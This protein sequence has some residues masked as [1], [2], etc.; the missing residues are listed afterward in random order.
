MFYIYPANRMEDLLTLFIKIRHLKPLPILAKEVVMVQSQGLQHWLNME[1]ANANKI[2][3]N[4]DFVLPAQYLWKL[5]RNLCEDKFPEQTPYSREVLSWRIDNL[6][7]SERVL[8]DE[9]CRDANIYWQDDL[10]CQPLKR[11]QLACQLADLYEQYLIYR[12]EWLSSWR[13]GKAIADSDHLFAKTEQWQMAIWQHLQQE[14]SYDPQDLLTIAEQQIDDLKHLL[15]RRVSLFGINALAPMWLQFLDL[16]SEHIDVHVFHLNP[17]FEFWGDIQ[18]DKALAKQQYLQHIGKWPETIESSEGINPLLA[19]LGQQGRE[20]LSLLHNI[21]NIEIPLYDELYETSEESP[22]GDVSLL[23]RLQ[24]DILTLHD[25]RQSPQAIVDDSVVITSAHSALREVQGLHDYLLQLFNDDPQLTPK[26]VIVMCPQVESY[27]AYIDS[28]FVRGWEDVGE[29]VPPLPCSI[30]DRIS[31]ESEPL[32]HAFS[33]L[34]SMAD[35]RYSVAS[36]LSLLQLESVQQRFSIH[37]GDIDKVSDWLQKA[38]IYWGLDA[39]HKKH[40]LESNQQTDQFTWQQGLS[41]LIK[42]FAFVDQD[43]LLDESVVLANVEGNDAVL[44]G[45]IILFLEQLQVMQRLL[46]SKKTPNQWFEFLTNQVQRLFAPSDRDYGLEI[47]NNA[48]AQLQEYAEQATYQTPI[49]LNVIREFLNQHF[50]QPDPGRQFMIG[51]ITFCSMMPMRSIPFKVVAVLGLN[52]GEYPRQRTPL[53]FDLMQLSDAKAGD[54]S[55]RG[56]DKYL[57]LEAMISAR[58]H[59]YL[60]YQGRDIKNNNERQPSIVLRELMEYLH[61]A[62]KWDISDASSSQLRQL[63]LQAFAKENYIASTRFPS[64]DKNWLALTKLDSVPEQQQEASS[65]LSNVTIAETL[66]VDDLIR[67]YQHPCRYFARQQLKLMFNETNTL[68][69]DVEPFAADG[70]SRYLFM[71]EA[72][73]LSLQGDVSQNLALQKE[74]AIK[75]GEFPDIPTTPETMQ[76]WQQQMLSFALSIEQHLAPSLQRETVNPDQPDNIG[77]Q[78]L[79]LCVDAKDSLSDHKTLDDAGDTLALQLDA[80][81]A[82]FDVA[83]SLVCV[84][85]RHASLKGKDLVRLYLNHLFAC[86]KHPDKNVTSYGYYFSQGKQDKEDKLNIATLSAVDNAKQVLS[87][88][89]ATYITGQHQA[90]LLDPEIAFKYMIN[91]Q[92]FSDKMPVQSVFSKAWKKDDFGYNS[93]FS[94]DPYI[95]YFFPECPDI[96]RIWPDLIDHFRP[97]FQHLQLQNVSLTQVND[98]EERF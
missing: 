35:G 18:T 82:T 77:Q 19:N 41:K 76:E 43:M 33:E 53:G 52:D 13:D 49:E 88:W 8:A 50:S 61:A 70:L 66:A 71:G 4:S 83:D 22:E 44:L 42:G 60:S 34:L 55:R 37:A 67:F 20:F 32:V 59:L 24:K 40:L 72:L 45:K 63:P 3:M 94:D 46:N 73:Q 90:L 97:L 98:V 48:L 86:V 16:L 91:R 36:I 84:D 85:Y 68:I 15:P 10:A 30:A 29:G 96:E 64:F 75:S 39:E 93:G 27:A 69:E 81:I 74:F 21:N 89:V 6:L 95:D 11:Y 7:Q 92:K 57:F 65:A 38:H 80:N 2:S 47:I 31:K 56:D 17:C 51:Q 58:Q 14:I 5:L 28:V 12:P 26:D 1:V 9:R 25:K 79:V 62:Y 54:R 87:Q 78:Q 23:L